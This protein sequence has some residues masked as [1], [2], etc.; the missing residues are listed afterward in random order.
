MLR[1][2]LVMLLVSCG[3]AQRR[4]DTRDHDGVEHDECPDV[5]EDRDGFQDEDGC[6]DLDDDG[7]GIKDEDDKC[8]RL[9]ED[10]DGVEDDDGCPE[11]DRTPK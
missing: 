2:A 3:A 1:A 11:G 5:P 4:V 7:D 10:K 6:P 9:A 8:P